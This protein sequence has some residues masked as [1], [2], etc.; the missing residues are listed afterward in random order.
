M[1]EKIVIGLIEDIMD[2]YDKSLP[3]TE[4]NILNKIQSILDAY[5]KDAA[6][7]QRVG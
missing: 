2:E 1:N 6:P 4:F 3:G 7:L 5:K